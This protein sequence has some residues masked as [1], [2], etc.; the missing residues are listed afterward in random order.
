VIETPLKRPL[1]HLLRRCAGAGARVADALARLQLPPGLDDDESWF[2]MLAESDLETA[3]FLDVEGLRRQP[4]P[5]S[6]RER[7]TA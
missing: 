1:G 2:Y 4:R 7:W 5:R 3:T 6:D